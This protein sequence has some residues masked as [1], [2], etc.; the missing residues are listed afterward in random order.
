MFT[1]DM[2]DNCG[3]ARIWNLETGEWIIRAP[4]DAKTMIG[5]GICSLTM[6]DGAVEK[7]PEP[8]IEPKPAAEPTKP[9][10]GRPKPVSGPKPITYGETS[11]K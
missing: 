5:M 7:A 8:T 11:E 2:L 6:P 1:P 9:K 3:R 4:I 10:S